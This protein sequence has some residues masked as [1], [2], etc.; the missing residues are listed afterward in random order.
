MV[1]PTSQQTRIYEWMRRN[2]PKGSPIV[3]NDV[4]SM[5]T[6]INIVGP[7]GKLLL[8]EL[9][10]SDFNLQAFTYKVNFQLSCDFC[11]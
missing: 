8:N 4:T 10:N 11:H 2:L 6:V 1:S 5:Y 7:K 9:S 3:L